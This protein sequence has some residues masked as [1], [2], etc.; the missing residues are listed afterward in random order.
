MFFLTHLKIAQL[1][2]FNIGGEKVIA[3]QKSRFCARAIAFNKA[4]FPTQNFLLGILG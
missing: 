3:Q 4:A 1:D 2:E